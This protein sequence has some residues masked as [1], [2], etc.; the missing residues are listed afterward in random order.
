[1]K[2]MERIGKKKYNAELFRLQL[3]ADKAP[4]MG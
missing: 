3:G 2:N 1:M 4:G